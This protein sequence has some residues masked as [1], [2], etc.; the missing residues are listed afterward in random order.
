MDI[1]TKLN[2]CILKAKAEVAFFEACKQ[3][4][5][6]HGA[7]IPPMMLAAF[8]SLTGECQPIAKEEAKA[9]ASEE[10]KRKGHPQAASGSK[11][12]Y[13]RSGPVS[14]SLKDGKIKG[15][16]VFDS[17]QDLSYGISGVD[18]T[19]YNWGMTRPYD[20]KWF[21]T[22]VNEMC[23]K[24]ITLVREKLAKRKIERANVVAFKRSV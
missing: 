20:P 4:L 11:L 19:L 14:V 5:L 18:Q 7:I 2:Q 23:K 16:M 8:E 10:K 1:T 17:L 15:K 13:A 3:F 22:W 24:D 12:L 21:Q 9:P 6:D